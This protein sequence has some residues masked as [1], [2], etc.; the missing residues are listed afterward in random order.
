MT[1]SDR[2]RAAVPCVLNRAKGAFYCA[3]SLLAAG[4]VPLLTGCDLQPK[5]GDA[6]RDSAKGRYRIVTTCGMVTDIVRQVAGEH[7]EVVGLMGEGVD[8]HLYRPTPSD[9]KTLSTAD[10]V[11]YSG[12]LL[13]GRM[14]ETFAQLRQRG[15]TVHAVTGVIDQSRLLKPEDVSGHHDPHVWM[16]VRMWSECVGYVAKV[17]GD[18]DPNHRDEYLANAEQYQRQLQALD[19]YVREV[20][21]TIPQQQRVLVTAH[22]AF[23]YFARAYNIPVKAPQ[24]ISTEGEP[25]VNDINE[26]VDFLAAEKIRAIFVE[27]SVSQDN[28]KAV[29]EGA[30]S[31]GW[32]VEIGGSLFSDA[33][34][35]PGTYEGTYV[36][37]IDHNATVIA[38]ALGG[39]APER[40]LNGK[41]SGATVP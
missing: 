14:E 30:A 27:S 18:Y 3:L 19:E 2:F 25:G 21:A 41:L 12:L 23:E 38:R 32:K 35:T 9:V 34:G 22:D 15:G 6:A 17:L 24:G 26:L 5:S 37:M 16:D 7:A 33:M 8:P 10:V 20:I 40:G 39:E 31:K 4:F 36:G 11:L 29:I 28:L 1:H 13:E